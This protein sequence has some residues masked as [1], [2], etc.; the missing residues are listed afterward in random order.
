MAPIGEKIS[1]FENFL[2]LVICQKYF[3]QIISRIALEIR[4]II[5]IL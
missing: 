4:L 3:Q 1:F 2:N 5:I